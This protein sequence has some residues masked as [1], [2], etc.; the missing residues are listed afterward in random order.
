MIPIFELMNIRYC[1]PDHNGEL[2]RGVNLA[3][4]PEE[5]IGL[6][7]ENGSGKS[8][9]LHIGAGLIRPQAGLVKFNGNTCQCEKDFVRSRKMLGYLLQHSEDQLFCPSVLEDVAFG[10]YNYGASLSEAR[11]KA[12]TT[13]LHLGITHLAGKNGSRLSGGE[14]KL[15]AL[16]TLLVMPIEL[17]FLDEP[18]NDL[19]KKARHNVTSIITQSGLPALVISHDRDF[20]LQVCTRFYRL[21]EGLIVEC[22]KP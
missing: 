15:A 3:L 2:L 18:T 14:Q 22:D 19:D 16:A 7:G 11:D 20:M 1:Y 5:R 13:L 12:Q 21:A 4:H 17:L 10:P 9:L 8:T 6:L